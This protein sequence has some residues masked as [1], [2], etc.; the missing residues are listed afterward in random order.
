[1]GGGPK[2]SATSSPTRTTAPPGADRPRRGQGH[3]RKSHPNL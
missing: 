3:K 2:N 1:V